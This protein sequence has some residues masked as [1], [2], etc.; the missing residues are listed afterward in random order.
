MKNFPRC[1]SILLFSIAQVTLSMGEEPA[2]LISS[3]ANYEKALEQATTPIHQ[4]YLEHLKRL[5]GKFTQENNLDAALA[6]RAEIEG[7]EKQLELGI[8]AARVTLNVEPTEEESLQEWLQGREFRWEATSVKEVILTFKGDEVRVVADGREIMKKEYE[9]VSPMAF[10]FEW[11]SNDMNTFTIA[12]GKRDFT[13]F[14][15]GSRSTHGGT[16]HARSGR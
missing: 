16:I 1:L 14:M 6:I 7:I 11:G 8:E 15:Q 10:Q 3:R 2:E 13:R 5:Q 4:K 9:I 12:D